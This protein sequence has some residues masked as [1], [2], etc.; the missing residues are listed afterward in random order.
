MGD[1]ARPSRSKATRPK[2]DSVLHRVLTRT[3]NRCMGG[4][5]RILPAARRH[6]A[7]HC[8]FACYDNSLPHSIPAASTLDHRWQSAKIRDTPCHRQRVRRFLGTRMQCRQ[9]PHS[10]RQRRLVHSQNTPISFSHFLV[11]YS[12]DVRLSHLRRGNSNKAGGPPGP[13]SFMPM[14]ASRMANLMPE[15]RL[16]PSPPATSLRYGADSMPRGR[17]AS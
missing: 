7:S 8:H 9:A 17:S 3:D 16:T 13:T 14:C 4:T 1:C 12:R 10:D 15:W 11:D 6:G 2:D 5:P